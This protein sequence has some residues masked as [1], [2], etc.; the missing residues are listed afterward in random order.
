MSKIKTDSLVLGYDGVDVIREL[1]AEIPAGKV[2]SVVGPNGC[3]KSTLLRAMARLMKPRRGAVLLDGEQISKLPTREVARRLGLLPQSPEAPEGLTVRELAA[4]GRY[5]HQSWLKQWSKED[6]R[7]VERAMETTGVLE[8]ADRSLD[9]LSGGQRQRAWISMAL[10]QETETLLL[11][12]PTT[13]LDM[14]HQLEVLQLLERL[15][16]EE[17]RT[18]LMVLH[19]LNNASRYSDHIVALSKGRVY[20]AGP[21]EKIM[22]EELFREVFGVEAEIVPDPRSGIPLCIPYGIHHGPEAANGSVRRL[23]RDDLEAS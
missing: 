2:T 13:Y 23:S 11:D 4:Q 18:I 8:F 12:E 1:E 16:R 19:D 15:N 20:R 6:E 5:P 3:G 14:A 17:G 9:T 21:P 10:A 7:A 22:T